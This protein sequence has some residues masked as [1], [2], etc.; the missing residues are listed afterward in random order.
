MDSYRKAYE[1]WA[2]TSSSLFLDGFESGDRSAWYNPCP[3]TLDVL[4]EAPDINGCDVSVNGVVLTEPGCPTVTRVHWQWGDGAENDS[5]FPATHAY[6]ANGSY[7]V[8]A[9]AF[10][11]DGLSASDTGN[12]Q[13]NSCSAP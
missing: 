9:T 6:A 5:W 7:W 12:L 2:Y 1:T 10:D 4:F 8:T 11:E 3:I 13:L